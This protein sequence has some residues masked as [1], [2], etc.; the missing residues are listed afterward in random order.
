[1][2]RDK[3]IELVNMV[4]LVKRE[5]FGALTDDLNEKYSKFVD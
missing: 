3:D 2:A 5:P 1:M 4:W